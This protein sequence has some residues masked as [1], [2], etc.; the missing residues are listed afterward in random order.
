MY[1]AEAEHRIHRGRQIVARQRELVEKLAETA[2]IAVELLKVFET[3][4]ALLENT[5]A[6]YQRHE[7]AVCNLVELSSP[8][9]DAAD[10]PVR[11]D[12]MRVVDRLMEILR[13]GG[14]HC[15]LPQDTLH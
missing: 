1:V 14:Y 15:E 11:D 5:L 8:I 2:P 13:A 7:P 3:S 9:P 10:N 12:E 6:N 4:L